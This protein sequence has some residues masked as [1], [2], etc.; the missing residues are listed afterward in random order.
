VD[1]QV[2]SAQDITVLTVKGSIDTYTVRG[3]YQQLD[4]AVATKSAKLVVNLAGVDFMDSSGLAALVQGM[5]KCR[6]RGGD[7]HL[8][9]LQQPV[10]M[11][12]ELTRLD[13]ALEIFPSEGD[14]I[15]S[16]IA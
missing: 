1:F 8:C 15:T 4:V 11:I 14:A 16:F 13:K 9:N 3:L 2:H 12:L 6:D 5:K 10:R 7:L